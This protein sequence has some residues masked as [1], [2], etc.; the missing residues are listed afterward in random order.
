[1]SSKHGTL[2]LGIREFLQQWKTNNNI[3]FHYYFFLNSVE[4]YFKG[5][6]KICE[7]TASAWY[8]EMYKNIVGAAHLNKFD[9]VHDNTRGIQM[10][11]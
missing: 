1:M 10:F 6:C 2:L 7:N 5:Y 11:Y 4:F 8:C 3:K 9:Q